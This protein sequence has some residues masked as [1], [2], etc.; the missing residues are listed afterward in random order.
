[1]YVGNLIFGPVMHG[2]AWGPEEANEGMHVDIPMKSQSSLKCVHGCFVTT[3]AICM[4]S[5]ACM[6]ICSEPV[7]IV[8]DVY[9]MYVSPYPL[10][11]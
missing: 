2:M 4:I 9:G 6:H 3:T 5:R 11:R 7:V 10:L 8:H 1:M